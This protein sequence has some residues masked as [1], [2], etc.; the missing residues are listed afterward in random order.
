MKRITLAAGL[1]AG[2]G[3]PSAPA[4]RGD[5]I[6]TY[7]DRAMKAPVTKQGAILTAD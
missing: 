1:L 7:I 2:M 6:V 5:D 3:L 4:A